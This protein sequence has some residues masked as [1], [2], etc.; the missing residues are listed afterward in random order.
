MDTHKDIHSYIRTQCINTQIYTPGQRTQQL[1]KWWHTNLGEC[2]HSPTYIHKY[3][4]HTHIEYADK[5]STLQHTA[6]HCNTLQH[7]ATHCS[8]HT[9]YTHTLNTQI[10]SAHCNTLQHTATHCNTLQHT[11]NIH[12][13][14]EYANKHTRPEDS[15]IEAVMK[16]VFRGLD[17][18]FIALYEDRDGSV[19]QVVIRFPDVIKRALYSMKKSPIISQKRPAFFRMNNCV[20][21]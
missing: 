8:T 4:I 9:I 13:H 11:Y 3:N 7:T 14:I 6:T 15:T 21:R 19:S 17:L 5:L 16:H 12:T 10:N 1:K 2:A 18:E 20:W